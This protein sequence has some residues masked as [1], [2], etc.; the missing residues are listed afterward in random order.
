MAETG[1][2]PE[3]E[4]PV[5]TLPLPDVE[6]LGVGAAL[7]VRREQLGWS[8]ADVAAWL[9]IRE[10]Y[11]EALESGRAG[12][13][14]AEAYALGFLRTYGAA[15]GFDASTLVLRYKREGKG[16]GGK[17]DL[18]FPAPVPDRRIPPGVSVSLGLAVILA[19]YVGWYHFIGHAPPTPERVPPV[20]AIIPD[21]QTKNA[22]SPQVASILPGPDAVPSPKA[23]D[24]GAASAAS[25]DAA[26]KPAQIPGDAQ[27]PSDLTAQNPDFSKPSS[28]LQNSGAPAAGTVA[29]GASVT[30][31]GS[32]TQAST[33]QPVAEPPAVAAQG[34]PG[35]QPDNQIIMK[36][37]APSWV[38]VKDAS[39]KV[40]Y[41]HIMQVDD[42]WS[43]PTEGGPY[44][45][46]VGNAGGIVLSAGSV[47]TQPL[48]RKGA[49]R[50][51]LV[52]TPEAITDGSLGTGTQAGA[53]SAGV[54][55]S[56]GAASGAK[57]L[58]APSSSVEKSSA[59]VGGAGEATPLPGLAG[60][61]QGEAPSADAP[62]AVRPKPRPRPKP[63]KKAESSAD[64][65]NAR[66]LQGI[67]G[68]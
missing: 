26:V 4:I 9:R 3:Q 54:S 55:G 63:Q 15:L 49:V 60:Q 11:L 10:S 59:G 8:L 35:H 16:G 68:H 21:A 5:F 31:G 64:D 29:D 24:H 41:D 58:T 43:V 52:L 2:V 17:P 62:A 42:Q 27:S 36:A 66:Q 50:R 14:P 19:S 25:H 45:L 28:D 6:S 47:T 7:R 56:E 32:T 51:K 23:A 18:T 22:P 57:G 33:T 34:V 44:S 1:S 20:A 61:P 40:A 39:G 53:P 13:F 30:E 48:G 46:T 37:I 67:T 12:V 38:Q 65:L